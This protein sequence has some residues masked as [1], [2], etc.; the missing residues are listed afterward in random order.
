LPT[1][2]F[3]TR[4]ARARFEQV[5][6][7]LKIVS[8]DWMSLFVYPLSGGFKQWCLWPAALTKPALILEQVLLPS[9]GPL[10]AFRLMTVFEKR[11]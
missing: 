4:Q 1:L 10:L 8:N 11:E 7:S 5:V 3:G 9:L 6:P 2:L